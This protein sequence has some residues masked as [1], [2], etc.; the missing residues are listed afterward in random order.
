MPCDTPCDTQSIFFGQSRR[1]PRGHGGKSPSVLVELP[2][3]IFLVKHLDPLESHLWSHLWSH[4]ES[5]HWSPLK[6]P[7]DPSMSCLKISP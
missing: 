2:S 7:L 1:K 5:H 3:E 6:T 4:L